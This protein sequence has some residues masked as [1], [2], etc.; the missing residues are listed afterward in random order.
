MRTKLFISAALLMLTSQPALAAPTLE[1]QA[2]S[3]V[4]E[5]RFEAAITLLEGG[6]SADPLLRWVAGRVALERGDLATADRFFA[7][8]S[9]EAFWGRVD[10]LRA[11]GKSAEA[12]KLT[13]EGLDRALKGEQRNLLCKLMFEQ[14][15]ELF[16]RDVSRAV[17][18][19]DAI[20]S[21]QPSPEL[22][23]S[24]EDLYLSIDPE[25]GEKD[26]LQLA[27]KRLSV[28]PSH[29]A[30]RIQ[31]AAAMRTRE[32][33]RALRLLEPVLR[34]GPEAQAVYAANMLPT[35]DA[36]TPQKLTLLELVQ[37]RFPESQRLH[38]LRLTLAKTAMTE[39]ETLG[40]PALE[41]LF[42]V[43]KIS[44][45]ARDEWAKRPQDPQ[46]RRQRWLQVAAHEGASTRGELARQAA[47][48]AAL[49][50]L[51]KLPAGPTRQ[52]SA[53][54]LLA[55]GVT[56][57]PRIH[58]EALQ[59]QEKRTETLWEL[60]SRFPGLT[61]ACEEL[62]SRLLDEGATELDAARFE[63]LCSSATSPE[64]RILLAYAQNQPLMLLTRYPGKLEVLATPPRPLT[65]LE[66]RV[67]PEAILRAAQAHPLEAPID[68]YLISP[69]LTYELPPATS[70][71]DGLPR[72]K[73]QWLAP[74]LESELSALTVRAEELRQTALVT[75]RPLR[76]EMLQQLQQLAV[77][78]LD[79]NTPVPN[80]EL[81]V[82]DAQGKLVRMR[83]DAQGLAVLDKLEG[84]LKLMARLDQRLGF[85][86]TGI[87]GGTVPANM[88][89]SLF[90]LEKA[91]ES[92]GQ[93]TSY[94]VVK[95][96]YSGPATLSSYT[97]AREGLGRALLTTTQVQLK[98]GVGMGEIF[99]VGGGKISLTV[100]EYEA[101]T[102]SLPEPRT[103]PSGKLSLQ[104]EP[105]LPGQGEKL[106]LRIFNLAESEPH[107]LPLVVRVQLPW[108]E[109]TITTPLKPEGSVVELDLSLLL[110]EELQQKSAAVTVRLGQESM[111][112]PLPY[113]PPPPPMPPTLPR[114]GWVGQP[115]PYQA[116]A[117]V[118]LRASRTGQQEV[119][120]VPPGASLTLPSAG[121]W[122]VVSWRSGQRSVP[123]AMTVLAPGGT[124]DA[125]GRWQG[126]A[127]ALVVRSGLR[128][129]L[130]AVRLP[131][132]PLNPEGLAGGPSADFL[133]LSV[134]STAQASDAQGPSSAP[135][136]P[137]NTR[138]AQTQLLLPL[139]QPRE[140]LPE[141]SGSLKR[142]KSQ[143]VLG[144]GLPEGTRLYAY[145]HDLSDYEAPPVNL[146]ISQD[147]GATRARPR[148]IEAGRSLE[149]QQISSDLLAE[150]VLAA[151]SK[152]LS[153]I[154]F[155]DAAS[156]E[157]AA[158]AA[159]GEGVLGGG[160][161][162]QAGRASSAKRAEGVRISRP[163][164][165]RTPAS[166]SRA[167][168]TG[169]ELKPGPWEVE[170]PTSVTAA[171]L[172]LLARTPE[173]RW[174]S[175]EQHFAIQGVMPQLPE[176]SAPA[177]APAA[178]SGDARRLVALAE[179]LPWPE[180]A[181]VYATLLSVPKAADPH[182]RAKLLAIPPALLQGSPA[183]TLAE[184]AGQAQGLTLLN[185]AEP[186]SFYE[187]PDYRRVERARQAL[188]MVPYEAEKA[189][190]IARRL[191]EEPTLEPWMRTRAALT[192]WA[193]EPTDLEA[194][195]AALAGDALSLQAARVVVQG[196]LEQPK[197]VP[198]LWRLARST[199]AL[200]EE[201]ALAL[202]A[203][204]YAVGL[205]PAKLEEVFRSEPAP[206]PVT[207]KSLTVEARPPLAYAQGILFER[208]TRALE[209]GQV[210]YEL[211][212]AARVPAARWFPV[213]LWI[214]PTTLPT[215]VSCPQQ[216]GV[217]QR[218][219]FF[220]LEPSVYPQEVICL[221][222]LK[223]PSSEP[224]KLEMAWYGPL[225][226]RLG[227]GATAVQAESAR[228]SSL[229]DPMSLDERLGVALLLAKQGDAEALATLQKLQTDVALTAETLRQVQPVLLEGARVRKDTALF[230]KAF[231]AMRERDKGTELT[232][233]LAAEVAKAFAEQ[234]NYKR[235]LAGARAV[236][237]ARF[238]EELAAIQPLETLNLRMVSLRLARILMQHSLETP[239]VEQ[240]RYLFASSL[241][242][243]AEEGQRGKGYT[244]SSLRHT[245][246]AELAR[247][248]LLY[249]KSKVAPEAAALMLDTIEQLRAPERAQA[250][251][252]KL[253]QRYRDTEVSWQLVLVDARS[254]LVQGQAKAAL[255]LLET[256]ETALVKGIDGVPSEALSFV[257]L[258]K[259]R[260][261]EA[262]GRADDA[263]TSYAE[264][265]EG[266]AQGEAEARAAWLRRT[267]PSLRPV[268]VL[269]LSA[270]RLLQ[271]GLREGTNVEVTAYRIALESLVLQEAGELNPEEV[272]VDGLRPAAVQK[273]QVNAQGELPL[274]ALPEGAYL[275]SVLSGGI[276]YRTLLI[277]SNLRLERSTEAGDGLLLRVVDEKGRGVP[278]A[279][280]WLFGSSKLEWQGKTDALGSTYLAGRQGGY[281]V[282]ARLG[283]KYVWLQ[284]EGPVQ[285]VDEEVLPAAQEKNMQNQQL[286]QENAEQYRQ[287]FDQRR[288]KVKAD[289]L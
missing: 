29:P 42:G 172:V 241:L 122:E 126:A 213:Q 242:A 19:L 235:A 177:P 95:P 117:D 5:G 191:L 91:V 180:Q 210:S 98:D 135:T 157:L 228:E 255:N 51:L 56:R 185:R 166:L 196:K 153:P 183:G 7:G 282:L 288:V 248:L 16:S 94:L 65:V 54:E 67:E 125:E 47:D 147:T 93:S 214:E 113:M 59:N 130:P 161:W 263:L 274:P 165:E 236:L 237:D 194:P 215:R 84:Q 254:K 2:L 11:R 247:F 187:W 175:H 68:A 21:L 178:W 171:R 225:G 146:R 70:G 150:E 258:D 160:L 151:E 99:A 87:E 107:A 162:G 33:F 203:L 259:G 111:T 43:A 253:A 58:Y 41:A 269:G 217:E 199:E 26:L 1:E 76:M 189:Q 277:R 156:E 112:L 244:P 78:V 226:E 231:E 186:P 116:P 238:G 179:T 6:S 224:V 202:Q 38:E 104:F 245:A 60:L 243:T 271:V 40:S 140:G 246:V 80:A 50:G 96:G 39:D 127:P 275:L 252:G 141:I 193:A 132:Q 74:R 25:Q 8:S 9:P 240:A 158:P 106:K 119:R 167:I 181:Q 44:A 173:G 223:A 28:E 3:A 100:G 134:V 86:L 120:W 205:E 219:R 289:M 265:H 48:E 159:Y 129:F 279:R 114:I 133:W 108:G 123:V 251:A 208:G 286:L 209:Q 62:A 97:A 75:R 262:L 24:A 239:S 61:P 85:A 222:R 103:L 71:N 53:Q 145:L 27:R 170:L 287:L 15:R 4:L 142:G 168:A 45:E 89:G 264:V 284:G 154:N 82:L 176:S 83:T 30:A 144:Q 234:G 118:W 14:A 31:L 250:L 109:Q 268:E 37:R 102:L 207:G 267:R 52:A 131:G 81:S 164:P 20:L 152:E 138:R 281:S 270:P 163:V 216:P 232:L 92:T 227:G 155:D 201:R 110:Q 273:G 121:D 23:R 190:S 22:Q 249:P 66:H 124:L 257:R 72:L 197:L 77:L 212:S 143:L 204:V 169:F 12:A 69:D 195:L 233:E 261:L 229:A 128:T 221:I 115:L 57:E 139:S 184:L 278:E 18:L 17:V 90:L 230:L 283:E 34:E 188:A 105:V 148:G 198:S 32:P 73:R 182:I 192:L 149:G 55:Q 220:D 79:G 46:L 200:P 280:L 285:E 49:E 136:L 101:A 63:E 266:S 211:A 36:P 35:L 260:V 64:A 256:L 218:Q 206:S 13:L 10:V 174:L 272:R 137:E 88:P 276:P